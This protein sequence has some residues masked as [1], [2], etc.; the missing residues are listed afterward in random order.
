MLKQPQAAGWAT[1]RAGPQ[2]TSQ[3]Q[4]TV[5]AGRVGGNYGGWHR[6]GWS[7]LNFWSEEARAARS[8]ALHPRGCEH[9]RAGS[10]GGAFQVIFTETVGA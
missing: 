3:E 8:A 5:V 2:R 1:W 6:S 9:A 4:L 7:R 10:G